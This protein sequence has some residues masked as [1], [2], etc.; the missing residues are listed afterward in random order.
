MTKD[1]IKFVNA[2][3]DVDLENNIILRGS[4]DP[5]SLSLLKV[6]KY[7][8]EILPSARTGTLLKAFKEGSIPDIDLGMR[9]G[10]Y[11]EADGAF[12]LQDDTYIIDGLQRVT[13]AKKFLKE[14]STPRLGG[15]VHF[16][17]DEKWER[18]RF[19]ILN[20]TRVKLS[21]NIL[22]RNMENEYDVVQMLINLCKDST[23]PLANKVCWN[24][25][26]K[27]EEL[28][29]AITFSRIAGYVHSRFHRASSYNV[30]GVV[31]QLEKV[32]GI[33]GRNHLRTNIKTFWEMMN[34]CF[35][36]K[37][38]TF[39]ESTATLKIG[40]L[41]TLAI[42]ISDHTNFWKDSLLYFPRDIKSKLASL[43]VSDPDVNRMAS[44]GGAAQEILYQVVVKHINK[45]KTIN[46]LMPMVPERKEPE[47]EADPDN[48]I[49]EVS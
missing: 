11:K 25:R 37:D 15:V 5:E 41:F 23:F 30:V 20:T 13:A 21:G 34:E 12:Y 44:A 18:E 48:T 39:K 47:K 4:I 49:L 33:I 10:A 8:R 19:R 35:K 28:V 26:M 16:N 27:R 42:V 1:P 31:G 9:G 2:A 6:D 36:I 3:L 46:K 43:P 17:T 29:S 38:V 45:G 32:Y 24:Q 22:L 7:Q 40:F 14:G